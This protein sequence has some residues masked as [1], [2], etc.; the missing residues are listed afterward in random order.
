MQ[1]LINLLINGLAV[2]VTGRI[3]PGV[4]IDDF[5]TAIVVSIVLGVVNTFIKP[6]LILFTL[7]INILSLGLFTF[8]I[9]ALVILIVDSLVPGFKVNGFWAALFF[10]LVLS[11][12]S[13][14]IY[15]LTK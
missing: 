7:P 13:G 5:F 2:F 12:V 14:V 1:I 6:I 10:S 11:F 4:A 8:V 3:L 9:N 15:S